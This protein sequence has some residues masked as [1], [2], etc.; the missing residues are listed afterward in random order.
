MNAEV[1]KKEGG[2]NW[3]AE[4]GIKER[5]WEGKKMR[6]WERFS[7]AIYSIGQTLTIVVLYED[8]KVKKG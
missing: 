4:V 2:K 8:K 3:N 1:G 6:R 5:R 7:T